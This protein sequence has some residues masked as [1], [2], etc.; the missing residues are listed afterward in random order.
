MWYT[1]GTVLV[2]P[3][4]AH[5]WW[6]MLLSRTT[7]P[8]SPTSLCC[9]ACVAAVPFPRALRAPERGTNNRRR[10]EAARR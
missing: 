8:V 6:Y 9:S 3:F 5:P 1:V 2:V 7:P 4:V 10:F